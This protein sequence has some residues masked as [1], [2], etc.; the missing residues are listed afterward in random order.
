M[1][2]GQKGIDWETYLAPEDLGWLLSRID[3]DAWYPMEVFERMGLAILSE[4]AKGEL[5]AVRMW[6]R[7]QVESARRQFPQLVA[8]GDARSTLMRFR[9]LAAGFFD[10]D[11]VQVTDVDDG[12]AAVS[13]AYGMAPQAEATACHQS[14]GFFERLVEVAGARDIAARFTAEAWKGAP[15]TLIELVWSQD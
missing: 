15:R 10:Y 2:R 5:E 3:L 11:A 14:L 8:D 1:I 7:F 12:R 6:G 9:V 4:V 13:I